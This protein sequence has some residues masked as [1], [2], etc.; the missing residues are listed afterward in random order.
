ML[1]YAPIRFSLEV[2]RA[3]LRVFSSVC[4]NFVV[5]WLIAG[6]AAQD[7]FVLTRDALT[8]ILAW[9]FAARAEELVEEL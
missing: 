9:Y 6:L 1:E 3:H 7:P 2:T 4:S 8:A 5:V